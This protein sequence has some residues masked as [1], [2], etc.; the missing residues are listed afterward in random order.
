MNGIILNNLKKFIFLIK[1]IK[2]ILQKSFYLS[3]RALIQ[4]IKDANH[5]SERY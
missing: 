3:I 4:Q 5:A 1:K 2:L